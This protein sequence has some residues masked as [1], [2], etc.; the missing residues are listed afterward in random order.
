MEINDAPL[1]AAWHAYV[2]GGVTPFTIPGHKRAAARLWPALGAAVASDVPLFGGLDTVK[3]A[4][5]T[6]A[7]A[8]A[9][10]AALWGADWC[11]FSTGGSTHANQA[12]A[13]AVGRPGDTV[14][15]TRSAHR[16]TLLGLVLAG[17][18]PVWL[19]TTV[20]PRFGIPSGVSPEALRG[21]LAAHPSAR[22]VFLVEPSY[23]GTVSDL[24]ALIAASDVPVIV[25]QAWGAH[26]GFHPSLPPH[27]L[28]VGAAAL[29]T[30]AH[31]TLPA[32]SQAS[33]LLA[34]TD[35]LDP[36]RL[37]RAFEAG[38]T[39]S[40]AG[41]IL[42]STDAA[43][44]LLAARGPQ[45]LDSLLS[46]VADAHARL[47]RTAG[48]LVPGPESFPAGRFDP[49]KLVVI[50][51]GTG[52]DGIAVE[53]DLIAAGVPVEMADRDTIVPI[54]TLA[55]TRE[56]VDRLVDALVGLVERH[57]GPARPVGL[58]I[59]WGAP[60]EAAMTPRDAFFADHETVPADRAVGR[61]CAEVVAP[62][63]PGVPVLVPGEVV[64]E[65]LLA[66]LRAARDA[67]TR[68][69]YAAD[70]TLGTLQVVRDA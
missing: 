53:R 20:D 66:G 55:D 38:N 11:R 60:A 56:S 5:G 28:Q 59:Q 16:S 42:A 23:L 48:L 70:P 34:R 32:Y 25:D 43:R 58:A 63:P 64:T 44:A 21:A 22:A 29:V 14:L 37:D 52:A 6:L 7:D 61:V 35:R 8:E 30:S 62:Y 33:L 9:R 45:L 26:F 17:L 2:D 15:V 31:K 46:L 19:P 24:P 4:G 41:S 3:L 13:L 68:I 27:A 51:S 36:D 54:V 49:A 18:N 69:A 10:A 57:R 47:R 65:S 39:T 1:L 50:L 67:G 40:P 12:I